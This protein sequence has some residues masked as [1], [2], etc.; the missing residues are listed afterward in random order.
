MLQGEICSRPF[1]FPNQILS[2]SCSP[3]LLSP[4]FI[5]AIHKKP[6]GIEKTRKMRLCW[7]EAA[8]AAV[9]L[10]SGVWMIIA[11]IMKLLGE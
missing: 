6:V 8:L 7:R 9:I 5:G 3:S 2:G 10:A 4:S 1:H 11:G